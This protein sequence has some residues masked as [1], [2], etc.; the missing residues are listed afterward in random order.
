MLEHVECA[1]MPEYRRTRVEGGTYFFTVVTHRR[2]PVLILAGSLDAMKD[3]FRN[4]VQKRP[5]RVDAWV[6]LP[7]H[8]HC[9]WTMPE[10]D[11]DYPVRWAMV[12]KELTKQLG[13]S[14]GVDIAP[15]PSRQ[16]RR[17]GTLWQRRYWEHQIRDEKDYRAHV[18]YIHFNPVKHGLAKAPGDWTR[19]SFEGWVTRGAYEEHWGSDGAVVFPEGFAGE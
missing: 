13:W 8:L 11:S 5:F 9:I 6:V 17:E 12:K 15:S 10:G 18:D 19:S 1:E 2:Q 14:V 16:R 3:V 7:D 4:V